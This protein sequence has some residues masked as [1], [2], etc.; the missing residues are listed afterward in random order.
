MFK[1]TFWWNFAL[2]VFF[3]I[4]VSLGVTLYVFYQMNAETLMHLQELSDQQAIKNGDLMV[5][6]NELEEFKKKNIKNIDFYK[7]TPYIYTT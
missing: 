3:L 7:K 1:A 4:T 2:I 6:Q 5:K